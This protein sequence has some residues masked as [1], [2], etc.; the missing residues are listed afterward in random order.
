M[1]FKATTTASGGDLLARDHSRE[2]QAA[3][4]GLFHF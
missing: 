4:C 1:N 2:I 3:G